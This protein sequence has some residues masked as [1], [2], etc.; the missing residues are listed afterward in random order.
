MVGPFR[1][2][3]LRTSVTDLTSV[4]SWLENINNSYSFLWLFRKLNETDL[5]NKC[6][7][8][9][10]EYEKDVS[11]DLTEEVNFLRSIHSANFQRECLHPW[12]LWN[13][14]YQLKFES[15]FPNIVI[16]KDFLYDLCGCCRS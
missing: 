4:F 3:R 7:D 1:D 12:E 5:E 9:C 2:F 11:T 15:L 13:T 16:D 6:L 14:L 10:R 8:F